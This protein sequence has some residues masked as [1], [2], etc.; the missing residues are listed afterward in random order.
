MS[1]GGRAG[2]SLGV[3]VV[4]SS[5]KWNVQPS[6]VRS[7]AGLGGW[8]RIQRKLDAD[9]ASTS[10]CKQARRKEIALDR[11]I[12]AKIAKVEPGVRHATESLQALQLGLPLP[13]QSNRVFDLRDEIAVGI[14]DVEAE[15][16]IGMVAAVVATWL[17]PPMDLI[18]A[19]RALSKKR[20]N[21]EVFS[22]NVKHT[23]GHGN[24]T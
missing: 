4:K 21:V 14:A 10:H 18:R 20:I 3:K 8:R 1:D 15:A 22:S 13:Q 24:T 12:A 2:P 23:A 7:I 19:K 11:S 9:T 17:A 16:A 6:A 5:H